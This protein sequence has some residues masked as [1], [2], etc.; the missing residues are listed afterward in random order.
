MGGTGA[1][2]SNSPT[3][4]GT[5]TPLPLYT[6]WFK[7]HRFCPAV[8]PY[9]LP[10]LP[11]GST[12]QGRR[13]RGGHLTADGHLLAHGL[14]A[15]SHFAAPTPQLANIQRERERVVVMYRAQS[16]HRDQLHPLGG[17]H[18][19][20]D[21]DIYIQRYTNKTSSILHL[22]SISEAATKYTVKKKKKETTTKTQK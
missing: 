5:K 21:R 11:L 2:E 18:V 4:L 10:L 16:T 20:H 19:S 13:S 14:S 9:P 6:A 17:R 15:A 22:C 3:F 8:R 7:P 12:E 1:A